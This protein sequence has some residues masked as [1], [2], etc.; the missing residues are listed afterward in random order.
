[1]VTNGGVTSSY[2]SQKLRG[3][4]DE[5][6]G[7]IPLPVFSYHAPRDH[8]GNIATGS[9]GKHDQKGRHSGGEN[10]DLDFEELRDDGS[11]GMKRGMDSQSYGSSLQFPR[12]EKDGRV[13]LPAFRLEETDQ[14]PGKKKMTK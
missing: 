14:S 12:D 4:Q 8:N 11:L 13:A 2:A 3:E 10:G 6:S 1:M 9:G 5:A 7:K